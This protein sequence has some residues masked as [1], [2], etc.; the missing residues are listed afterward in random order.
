MSMYKRREEKD[1]NLTKTDILSIL[2]IPNIHTAE[3]YIKKKKQFRG[4]G[5]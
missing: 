1:H 3:A 5:R 4:G 2:I